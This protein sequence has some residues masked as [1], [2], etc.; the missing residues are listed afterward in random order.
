M[1]RKGQE[2][3]DNER[4]GKGYDRMETFALNKQLKNSLFL[5]ESVGI[6]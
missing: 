4:T 2:T 6:G 5:A 1:A 3:K